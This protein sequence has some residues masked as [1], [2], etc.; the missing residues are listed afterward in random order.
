VTDT[1]NKE[2]NERTN[3]RTDGRT[4][5]RVASDGQSVRPSAHPFVSWMEFDTK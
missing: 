3:K 1:T 2:T 5:R 4:K